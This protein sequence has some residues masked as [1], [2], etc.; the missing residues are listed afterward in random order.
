MPRAKTFYRWA[1]E[2]RRKF[3]DPDVL[4]LIQHM[5][6]DDLFPRSNWYESHMWYLLHRGSCDQIV[7]GF[8][9]AWQVFQDDTRREWRRGR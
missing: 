7:N 2:N 9:K 8:K 4:R 5:K 6:L 1:I 3:T